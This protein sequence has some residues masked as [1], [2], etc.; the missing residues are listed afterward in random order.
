MAEY[1]LSY[2]A[3]EIDEKL[4]LIEDL[5]QLLD[6]DILT[7]KDGNLI[8]SFSSIDGNDLYQ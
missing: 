2:T 7:D 1:Q 5:K 6:L 8:L 3:K 4:G